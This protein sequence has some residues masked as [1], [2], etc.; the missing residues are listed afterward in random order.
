MSYMARARV[1]RHDEPLG[2]WRIGRLRPGERPFWLELK[3]SDERIADL[4]R[5]AAADGLSVDARVALSLEVRLVDC[6]LRALSGPTLEELHDQ[7]IAE[8]ERHA[9]APAPELRDWV[10]MLRRAATSAAA[11]LRDELPSLALPTRLVARVAPLDRNSEVLAAADADEDAV[12]VAI[13]C[14]I[15]A[16]LAGRTLESW[17]YA[18]AVRRLAGAR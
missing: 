2:G 8:G 9:L 4:R 13:A 7:A 11:S 15:A 5:R 17:A 14:D 6:E 10:A 12:D 16:A 1:Q 18:E 3:L